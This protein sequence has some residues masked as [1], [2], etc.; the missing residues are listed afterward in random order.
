M[1]VGMADISGERDSAQSH[2]NPVTH[3]P[4]VLDGSLRER[5]DLGN[6]GLEEDLVNCQVK[7]IK[8]NGEYP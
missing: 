6:G 3:S 7:D 1:R 8:R 2:M 5:K 4:V